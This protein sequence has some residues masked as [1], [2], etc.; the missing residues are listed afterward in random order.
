MIPLCPLRFASHLFLSFLVAATV[1]ASSPV[2]NQTCGAGKSAKRVPYPFGFSASCGIELDCVGGEEVDLRIAS[3]SVVNLTWDSVLLRLPAECNRSIEAIAPLFGSNY[4]PT[5]RNDL[6][7][8]G[9]PDVLNGC[10]IPKSFIENRFDV[11][12]CI[13][14]GGHGNISCFSGE[15]GEVEVMDL[16]VVERTWCQW[17]FSSI[18]PVDTDGNT[19]EFQ[20]LELGWW[21]NGSCSMSVCHANASCEPAKLEGGSSG[22]RCKCGEGLVG[23][24]YIN[25]SGCSTVPSG[26]NVSEYFSGKCGRRKVGSLIA[27][28]IAGA[29]LM[30]GLVAT[31]YFLRRRTA[32]RKTQISGKRLLCLAT[33]ENSVPFYSYKHI[34]KATNG[35]SEKQ[36]LGT[37][38]Y[39]AVYAGKLN[40]D[41]W[42]AI[43]KIC[44][45]NLAAL[46]IDRIGRGCV[47]EI[48]D[49]FLDPHMDAW[50][51]SSIHKVAELA[52]RCLA[53]HRDMRP[54][55]TEVAEELE[56]IRQS[57]CCPVDENMRTALSTTSFF[58]AYSESEKS[59][60][61]GSLPTKKPG[62]TT[63]KSF[64]AQRLG[65]CL[66]F[67]GEAK[68]E[69][70]AVSVHVAWD[71]GNSSP[72][73]SSLLNN[74]VQ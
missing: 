53:F 58:S 6:L 40:N 55:M 39:G 11:G 35:F 9:C 43:K 73:L 26:C 38:A 23:D 57:D 30:A 1:L 15:N 50:T 66:S 20:L 61:D 69:E 60:L 54:S 72:S 68:K 63:H 14:E 28:M 36:R 7:L 47:E 19:L 24:G 25:G 46:A 22:I 67:G 16:D 64:V 3:F 74:V 4:R 70:S 17:L 59:S 5:W 44:E 71:S 33:G 49:P 45:T 52:F 31:C 29:S 10:V 18:A 41:E 56:Q 51:L 32:L 27:G 62:V 65:D 12:N 13:V 34:E 37:G 8:Q 21:V 2:C 48:I 42:V